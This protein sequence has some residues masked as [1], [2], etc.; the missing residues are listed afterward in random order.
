MFCA[1]I[2]RSKSVEMGVKGI[3]MSSIYGKVYLLPILVL[4]GKSHGKL[5]HTGNSYMQQV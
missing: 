4:I 2:F 1:T 3:G 5:F